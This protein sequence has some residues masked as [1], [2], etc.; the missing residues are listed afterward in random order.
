M[1]IGIDGSFFTRKYEGGKEQV[2]MNLLKGLC[3][4]GYGKDM[5]VFGVKE[6]KYKFMDISEDIEYISVNL[7]EKVFKKKIFYGTWF[8]TFILPGMAKE[9]KV[10]ILLFPVAYTGFGKFTMPTLVIPHDIQFKSNSSIYKGYE[11]KLFHYLY[12]SDFKRRDAIIAI[13]G[14]DRDELKK[15]YYKYS[16]K[17]WLIYNPIDF[18]KKQS[19]NLDKNQNKYIFAN[20]LAYVH[21][22]LRTLLRAFQAIVDKTDLDLVISGNLYRND[23]ETNKLIEKLE[24]TG[25][26]IL[27]GYLSKDEFDRMLK[28]ACLFVNTSSFE[29]FGMAAVEAMYA[30]VPC[31]LADNSAVKEVTH[32]RCSYYRPAEDEKILAE[33]L[34]KALNMKSDPEYLKES[35]RIIEEE[36]DYRKISAQY[37]EFFSELVKSFN[38]TVI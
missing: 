28:N 29:G 31:L 12:G 22:N 17:T 35:S 1:K 24:Q 11:L 20:N 3:D 10:D 30:Q 4:L 38:E 37:L 18:A 33:S 7:H 15:Y 21:K 36:Y 5:K 19:N 6:A 34:L 32:E 13:S 25:R 27:S 9:H 26:L 16:E 23:M 14:Y 8:R 2:L